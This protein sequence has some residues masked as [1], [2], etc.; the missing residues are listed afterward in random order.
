MSNRVVTHTLF[1][2]D[3]KV[4]WGAF[5]P[6]FGQSLGVFGVPSDALGHPYLFSAWLKIARVP[7][8]PETARSEA[9]FK[10]ASAPLCKEG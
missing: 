5:W 9:I 4:P 3:L 10:I 7:S 1:T 2:S 6:A 8:P